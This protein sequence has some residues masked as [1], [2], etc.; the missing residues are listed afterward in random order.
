MLRYLI[1]YLMTLRYIGWYLNIRMQN[2]IWIDLTV[3]RSY[4]NVQIWCYI[5]V[6]LKIYRSYANGNVTIQDYILDDLKICRSYTNTNATIQHCILVD[7]QLYWSYH[8]QM[9]PYNIT[10]GLIAIHHWY[11]LDYH[12]CSLHRLYFHMSSLLHVGYKAGTAYAF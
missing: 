7:P 1:I 11:M 8:M 4:T 3:Y 9:L 5:L 2:Y 12:D 10:F 6:D